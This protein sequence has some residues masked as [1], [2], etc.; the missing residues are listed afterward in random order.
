MTKNKFHIFLPLIIGVCLGVI[1]VLMG[2]IPNI[3]AQCTGMTILGSYAGYL[4]GAVVVAYFNSKKW[5]IS[6]TTSA[7]TIIIASL[8]Y[9]LIIY[10]FNILNIG[11]TESIES[12][13]DGFIYWSKIGI[14]CGALS[15]TAMWLVAHGKPKLISIGAL[16]T[17][18]LGLLS[19]IYYF[20]I[21][22]ILEIYN[23]PT[24]IPG[25]LLDS[26]NLVGDIFEIVFAITLITVL[27]V[28]MI[29][30]HLINAVKKIPACPLDERFTKE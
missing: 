8:V 15:A 1:S 13:I 23:N 10:I 2:K 26:R 11:S 30:R 16:I 6:F 21:R 9:Y 24:P 17:T 4:L 27:F 28:F 19:I 25:G 29:K 7:L 14:V 5:I 18:Y 22:I 3:I 12:M 20:H